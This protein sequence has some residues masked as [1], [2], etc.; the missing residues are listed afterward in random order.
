MPTGD[1]TQ[2]VSNDAL[3]LV[4]IVGGGQEAAVDVDDLALGDERVDLRIVE[5]HHPHAVAVQPGGLDQGVAQLMEEQFRLAVAQ[6]RLRHRRTG[7]GNKQQES[8][9][10]EPDEAGH[11]PPSSIE[12]LNGK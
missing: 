6:D 3:D 8:D 7:G 2:L 4:G 9:H 10:E 5:Q 12:R 11:W 1:V